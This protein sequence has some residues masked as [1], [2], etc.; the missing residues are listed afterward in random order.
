MKKALR[1]TL[2][3]LWLWLICESCGKKEKGS[4][5]S[6]TIQEGKSCTLH[7]NYS[8]QSLDRVYWYRQEVGKSLQ[9]I[10]TLYS[11]G[12]VKQ[13]ERLT[14][15]FNTNTRHSSLNIRDPQ[16]EDSGTYLCAAST[17]CPLVTCSLCTNQAARVPTILPDTLTSL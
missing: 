1:S 8:S 6:L 3:V 4:P 13:E 12:A 5:P 2:A 14:A 11:N 16:P 7:C 10:F 17:Q 9:F 15:T